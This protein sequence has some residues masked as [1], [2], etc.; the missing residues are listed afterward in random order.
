M[1]LRFALYNTR[2]DKIL[3]KKNWYVNGNSQYNLLWTKIKE[4][5][6]LILS[7]A[8]VDVLIDH[9]KGGAVLDELEEQKRSIAQNVAL[10]LILNGF[11]KDLMIIPVKKAY[12]S[13]TDEWIEQGLDFV[14]GFRI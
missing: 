12:A 4:S 9:I 2:Q 7:S 8:G 11:D 10:F 14:N 13:Y 5:H 6:Y 3:C 1:S